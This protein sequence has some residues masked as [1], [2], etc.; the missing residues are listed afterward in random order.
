MCA[1]KDLVN[2]SKTKEVIIYFRRTRAEDVLPEEDEKTLAWYH[3]SSKTYTGAPLRAS[4]ARSAQQRSG[5]TWHECS[6]LPR[7]LWE[8][9]F[10]M[11]THAEE[12]MVHLLEQWPPRLLPVCPTAI[13]EKVP[14]HDN[15]HQQTEIL[16]FS[17]SS[18]LH[19][20]PFPPSPLCGQ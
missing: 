6:R 4:S 11:W 3:N 20:P 16:F 12:N 13:R 9:S 14:M 7:G 5:N 18:N 8:L 15:T 2:T 10:Q 1:N 17:Q 19:Q